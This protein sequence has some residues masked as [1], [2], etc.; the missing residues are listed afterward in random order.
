MLW[1]SIQ[2]GIL[3]LPDDT[4][5]FTGHEVIARV[6]ASRD[7]IDSGRTKATNVH[8][9]KY[10][11]EAEFVAARGRATPPADHQA[12]PAHGTDQYQC[13]TPAEPEANGARFLKIPI[14][15]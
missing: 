10:L 14:N 6:G 9:S 11:T 3:A 12:D 4:R 8:M 2:D 7:R 13:R 15:L 5:I 1:T